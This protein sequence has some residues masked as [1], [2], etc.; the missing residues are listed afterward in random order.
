M[1][2]LIL[3]TIILAICAYFYQRLSEK[4]KYFEKRGIVSPKPEF[5]FG[6]L[7]DVFF[8]RRHISRCI[9]DIYKK[10]KDKEQLVGFYNI[11]TP[12]LLIIDPEL[13]KQ[14][15]IKDFKYFRN[16]EFSTL[17]RRHLKYFLKVLIACTVVNHL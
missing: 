15:V 16:N 7:K 6:N 17:V 10:Y 14:I 8:K 4:H 9:D 1:I 3:I 11:T 13:V 12:Y 5:F 2:T